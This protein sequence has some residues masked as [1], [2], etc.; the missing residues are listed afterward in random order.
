MWVLVDIIRKFF[1]NMPQRII[2]RPAL[3]PTYEN[4]VKKATIFTFLML[5]ILIGGFFYNY[6]FA[7][8]EN[9]DCILT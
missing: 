8:S 3:N 5:L 9:N 1:S 4:M 2:K 7:D 6:Y